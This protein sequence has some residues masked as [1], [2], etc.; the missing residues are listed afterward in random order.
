MSRVS[1][2]SKIVK[3]VKMLVRSCFLITVIKCLK[4]QRSVGWLFNV[5]KTKVADSV[6]DSVTQSVTRSP[7]EL[8][9]DS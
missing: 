7:I 6:S 8:S 1:K 4:G 5:K 9:G 3:I 2:S